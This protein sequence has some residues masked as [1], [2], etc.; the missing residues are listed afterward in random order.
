MNSKEKL[1]IF[2]SDNFDEKNDYLLL[3]ISEDV[4][5]NLQKTQGKLYFKGNEDENI[6]LCS[7][8]KTFEVKNA[9]STNSLFLIPHKIKNENNKL[10]VEESNLSQ[11]DIHILDID[12]IQIISK[13]NSNIELN[14]TS[15]KLHKLRELLNQ[16]KYKGINKNGE[17][18]ENTDANMYSFDDLL[19]NIQASKKEI[20]KYLLDLNAF[21]FH[22]K[23]QVLDTSFQNELLDMILSTIEENNWSLENV[24]YSDCVQAL[25][26]MENIKY[27]ERIIQHGLESLSKTP[28][29]LVSKNQD[30]YS[31]D[32]EKICQFRAKQLFQKQKK[33][34]VDKFMDEWEEIVPFGIS[35]N[36]SM[37]KKF[38]IYENMEDTES[39]DNTN[40]NSIRYIDLDQL[41]HIVEERF[42]QL[43]TIKKEWGGEEI[44]PFLDQ[45]IGPNQTLESLLLKNSRKC[46]TL[47]QRIYYCRK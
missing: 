4:L 30:I 8:D 31:L 5:E 44:Q 29:S 6:V 34:V 36:L 25:N 9:E 12:S 26:L 40:L 43:F 37:L 47:D 10:L 18:I 2:F 28:R 13:H 42:E 38:I 7:N 19:D 35:P 14:Q 32:S 21:E 46:K 16:N 17:R 20:E 33:W 39:I 27:E 1:N 23:W 15:P 3:E 22:G 41:S 45:I 11:N 24:L